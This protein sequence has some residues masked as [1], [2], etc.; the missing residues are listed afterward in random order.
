M[1]KAR[2]TG[3]DKNKSPEYKKRSY[4]KPLII[5]LHTG[6]NKIGHNVHSFQTF[7]GGS[8]PTTHGPS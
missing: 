3:I 2:L 6:A 1:T 8:Y 7:E 4:E 5:L